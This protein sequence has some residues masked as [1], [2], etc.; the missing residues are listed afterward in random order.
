MAA[1][2]RHQQRFCPNFFHFFPGLYM[3]EEPSMVPTAAELFEVCLQML[4]AAQALHDI[5][6]LQSAEIRVLISELKTY[7]AR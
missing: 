4:A 3:T 6:Q 1:A 5:A 7:R 2:H